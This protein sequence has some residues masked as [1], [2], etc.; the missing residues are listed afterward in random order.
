MNIRSGHRSRQGSSSSRDSGVYSAEGSSSRLRQPCSGQTSVGAEL[1]WQSPSESEQVK[2]AVTARG[3]QITDEG[4][5]D[6]C[7]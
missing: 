6:M 7:V 3:R 5:E 4:I 1:P 2:M